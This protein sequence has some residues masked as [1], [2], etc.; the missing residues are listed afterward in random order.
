M[1]MPRRELPDVLRPASL[2]KLFNVVED[3]KYMIAY[4]VTFFLG[5]RRGE[6]CSLL[7]DRVDLD[8]LAIT[9]KDSKNPTRGEDGG[10]K[11]RVVCIPSC[12]KPIIEL[13]LEYLGDN[14]YF[15]PK[16]IMDKS[17]P[18]SGQLLWKKFKAD[19]R[20]AGLEKTKKYDTKGR[21]LSAFNYHSLR[22][23]Y[24][25]YLYEKGVQL[26]TIQKLLGHENIQT[27]LI[28]THL[29]KE[30]Q[31]EEVEQAFNGNGFNNLMKREIHR[32]TPEVKNNL[33]VLREQ[34]RARELELKRIE[35]MKDLAP[36]RVERTDQKGVIR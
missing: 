7:T 30:R 5:L 22:H 15:L 16:R 25:T 27:T 23:A 21:K 6:I 31:A 36:I 9:V 35:L 17:Q 4:I 18:Y 32:E 24:G 11:D 14:K 1:K 12:L 8:N 33:E 28:Y 19:L 20:R 26:H 34:N 2:K 3:P 29:S 13:W 10:G